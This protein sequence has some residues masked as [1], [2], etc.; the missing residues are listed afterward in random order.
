MH[1]PSHGPD[2]RWK[3][4]SWLMVILCGVYAGRSTDGGQALRLGR[5]Y[6]RGRLHLRGTAPAVPLLLHQLCLGVEDG[7]EQMAWPAFRRGRRRA[8][9]LAQGRQDWMVHGRLPCWTASR[10]GLHGEVGLDRRWL[11]GR[12]P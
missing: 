10:R 7:L 5:V 11:R 8:G 9:Q 4:T 2:G 1:V 12:L 3:R 6:R